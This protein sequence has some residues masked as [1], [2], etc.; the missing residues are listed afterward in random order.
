MT[1]FGASP[2]N[3]ALR[4]NIPPLVKPGSV[5]PCSGSLGPVITFV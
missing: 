3:S 4:S 1:R 5:G 2:G